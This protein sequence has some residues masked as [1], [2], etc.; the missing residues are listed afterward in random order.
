MRQASVGELYG[1]I[2][3]G[4][5][6]YTARTSGL[7]ALYKAFVAGAGRTALLTGD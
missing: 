6:P 1:R 4:D 7:T 3:R 2:S 5:T